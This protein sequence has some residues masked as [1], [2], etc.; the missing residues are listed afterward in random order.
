MK[1]GVLAGK[2]F[3]QIEVSKRSPPSSILIV[4]KEFILELPA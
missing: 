1:T 2:Y 4:I 3:T